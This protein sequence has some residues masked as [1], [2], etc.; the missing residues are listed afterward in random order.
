M[1]ALSDGPMRKKLGIT[2]LCY[3]KNIRSSKSERNVKENLFLPCHFPGDKNLL[4][5]K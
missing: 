1:F 4:V 2:K 5:T 3:K